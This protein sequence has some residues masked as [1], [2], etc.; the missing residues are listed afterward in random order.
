M[1]GRAGLKHRGNWIDNAEL[2]HALQETHIQRKVVDT[3]G[4]KALN[5][6]PALL[7]GPLTGLAEPRLASWRR[8]TE[9]EKQSS[10]SAQ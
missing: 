7:V 5:Q 2:I 1:R 4:I 10:S 6:R 9:P 3:D 8:S